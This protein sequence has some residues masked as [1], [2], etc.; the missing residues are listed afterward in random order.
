M[1]KCNGDLECMEAI[2]KKMGGKE[3]GSDDDDAPPAKKTPTKKNKSG[4]GDDE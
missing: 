1:E 2:A 4:D 3:P